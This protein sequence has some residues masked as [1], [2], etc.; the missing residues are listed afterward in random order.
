MHT[1]LGPSALWAGARLHIWGPMLS[2]NLHQPFFSSASPFF[3]SLPVQAHSCSPGQF[4]QSD[5]EAHAVLNYLWDGSGACS[6]AV[7][8]ESDVHR[9]GHHDL[10]WRSRRLTLQHE[11]RFVYSLKSSLSMAPVLN[12]A[13]AAPWR[14]Q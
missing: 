6:H 12:Y 2:A 9:V 13:A 14:R 8:G 3:F 1:P 4:V 11:Y 10:L 5:V 7:C